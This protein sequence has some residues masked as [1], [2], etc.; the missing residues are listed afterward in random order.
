MLLAIKINISV[1]VI[2]YSCKF[3]WNVIQ[4]HNLDGD[5]HGYVAGYIVETPSPC[6]KMFWDAKLKRLRRQT[7]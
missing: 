2:G 4:L 7:G 5:I 6:N 1:N 3:F